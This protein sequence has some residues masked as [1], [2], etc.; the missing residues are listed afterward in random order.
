MKTVKQVSK[1]AGVSVRALHHYDAIGLLKPTE[2]TEAGYR[3][4]DDAALSRLQ[5]ILLFRE[6][7][8][9]LKEIKEILDTPNFDSAEAI[10]QQ[11]ALLELQYKHI[12]ELI[13][14]A[15]EMQK[16][17]VRTM[18]FSVFDTS[19]MEALK[20]EANE[21]WG[22]TKAYR[23][24]E[25]KAASSQNPDEKSAGLMQVFS[26]LGARK[27]LA[28]DDVAVQEK[29]QELQQYITEHYYSCSNEIL[30]TLGEMYV[31]DER[32]KQNIDRVAGDGGAEF[33]K[34]AIDVFC[35]A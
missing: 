16:R 30:G 23:E 31:N 18:D 28:P 1:L 13:V 6:L 2:V 3:L 19:E 8:F 9:P 34:L 17:G 15:R 21:K 10:R 12:G 14:F 26:D 20:A 24:Y 11:I 27:H 22:K 29:I 35:K 4:Y 7:H 25:A 5:S 32:F 33:V